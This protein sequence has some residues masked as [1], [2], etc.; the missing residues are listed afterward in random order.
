MAI[1]DLT[2]GYYQAPLDKNSRKYTAFITPD[3]T[4]QWT[5]VPMGLKTS[6]AYF[7]RAI[8]SEV[9]RELLYSACF[10]YID[11]IIIFGKD[12]EEYLSK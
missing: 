9:L 2:K 3:G 7:Q 5:R 10:L 8:A 1:L 12:K 4:Y 6:G 11:D